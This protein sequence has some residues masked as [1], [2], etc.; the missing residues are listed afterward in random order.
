MPLVS[1]KPSDY[2]GLA[3]AG[4]AVTEMVVPVVLGVWI[5]NN[6]GSAPWGLVVGAVVG[7]VGSLAHLIVVGNRANRGSG[8]P[9]G[10]Q[11]GGSGGE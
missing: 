8:G 5:D 7:F 3:L 4:T 2:R 9:G 6:Y 10:G 11:K 1:E